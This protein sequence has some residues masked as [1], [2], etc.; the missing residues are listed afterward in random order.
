MTEQTPHEALVW[1]LWDAGMTADEIEE[2]LL[3]TVVIPGNPIK[4]EWEIHE[5]IE[6]MLSDGKPVASIAVWL[7]ECRLR[8]QKKKRALSVVAERDAAR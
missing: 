5:A 3:S 4:P 2:L 7:N 6:Q 8:F 1:G